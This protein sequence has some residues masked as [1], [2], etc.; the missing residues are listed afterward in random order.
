MQVSLHWLRDYVRIKRP[1]HEITERLM[2]TLC[3]VEE[4]RSVESLTDVLVGELL[5]VARHPNADTLWLTKVKVGAKTY[6]IVCGADNVG[7][8]DKVPVALPGTTLPSGVLIEARMIRGQRSEGMLCSPRELGVGEDRTGIWLLPADSVTGQPLP[9]ALGSKQDTF[10]L[11]IPANRPDCLGHLGVAREVAATFGLRLQEP[12]LQTSGRFQ[13]GLYKVKLRDPHCTRYTFAA[14]SGLQNT[15]SPAWLKERLNAVG[16]RPINAIV[17]IANF[18]MLELGQPLHAIDATKVHGQT[19]VVR[20]AKVGEML[21]TLDGKR[22]KPTSDTLLIADSKRSLGLAGIM[23]AADVEVT[24]QTSEVLLESAHFEAATIRRASRAIGLHTEASARFEKGI[25]ERLTLLAMR[26]T[27]D[28][29]LE[30]CGGELEQLTDV[31]PKPA[32]PAKLTLDVEAMGDFLG[33]RLPGTKVRAILKSL[34]FGV[35]GSKGR[36]TVT[37]PEWRSDI[38]QPVD[39]YEEVVRLHGYDK[40]PSTLPVAQLDVP[41]T[42]PLHELK[43]SLRT[44]LVGSGLVEVVT[45]TLLGESLLNL[46]RYRTDGLVEMANPLSEDHRYLRRTMEPRHL[47]AVAA[48]LRFRDELRFFELGTV[49]QPGQSRATLPRENV[50][51]LV[52]IAS[53][54][55]L[56]CLDELRGLLE[57]FRQRYHLTSR[58]FSFEAKTNGPYEANRFWRVIMDGTEV[59]RLAQY[60]YPK[61]WKATSVAFLTL[62]LAEFA[63]VLPRQWHLTS[64]PT[65]PP[66]GRDLSVYVSPELSYA[67]LRD[68]ITRSGQPILRALRDP[69]EFVRDGRRSLTV[70]LEFGSDRTLTD[71]EVNKAM[72]RIEQAVTRRGAE[73]RS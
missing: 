47:E 1:V 23:G 54:K 72:Q 51:L 21:T 46:G 13:L 73:V 10:D 7:I 11:D 68:V 22:R 55:Q 8:G 37:A 62:P 67:K 33:L 38:R 25:T 20:R 3:E 14:L 34:S 69:S 16:Q 41:R 19:I 60:A 53:S 27:V 17:D 52:T 18:V 36:L 42:P 12:H 4:I 5:D 44:T 32:K 50:K 28:L 58:G 70:H 61:T 45:H 63:T 64:P 40:V 9:K 48:N 39:L 49:F 31:Y 65:Y 30:I 71:V 35:S 15:E 66:V 56:D 59:G 57:L 2:N 6:R 24:K 29:L 26:R 43:Q